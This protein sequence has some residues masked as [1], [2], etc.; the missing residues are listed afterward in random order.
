LEEHQTVRKR[1]KRTTAIDRW[2]SGVPLRG[3]ADAIQVNWFSVETRNA[4]GK[5]TYYN[6][7]VTDLPVNAA[8]VAE[9]GACGRARWKACPRT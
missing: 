1:G 7:F 2:L 9:M 3:T 5:R 8:T 4:S 6:S